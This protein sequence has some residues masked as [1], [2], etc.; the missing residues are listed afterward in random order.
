MYT[1]GDVPLVFLSDAIPLR[2]LPRFAP[3]ACN[4]HPSNGGYNL[5]QRKKRSKKFQVTDL[6]RH[7][8]HVNLKAAG[9]DIGSDRHW[10]AVPEGRDE[11]SVREF[12]AF[13]SD[14]VALADWLA[15]SVRQPATMVNPS[16]ARPDSLTPARSSSCLRRLI[17]RR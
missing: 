8:Q 7:L 9:I 4:N 10:V 14:L 5:S 3:C 13:T 15:Q 6:P 12:G 16:R 1:T 11:V 2:R 17:L